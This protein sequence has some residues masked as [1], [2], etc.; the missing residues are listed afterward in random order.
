M[1]SDSSG[2]VS[3]V[4]HTRNRCDWCRRRFGSTSSITTIEWLSGREFAR[5][6]LCTFDECIKSRPKR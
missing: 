3:P 1:I 5:V 6:V 4:D 2:Y